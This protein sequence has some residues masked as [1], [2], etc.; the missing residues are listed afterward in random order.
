MEV[1]PWC[2]PLPSP[3]LDVLPPL[4]TLERPREALEPLE[5]LALWAMVVGAAPLAPVP[6]RLLRRVGRYLHT[7]Q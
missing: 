4:W 6:P 1:Y 7:S 3:R 5:V 2:P